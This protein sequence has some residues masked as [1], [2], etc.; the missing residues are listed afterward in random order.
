[1]NAKKI[2]ALEKEYVLQTYAR[3][4]FVIT[5]G[6]GVW[7]IDSEGNRYLDA[8]SGIAVNALGHKHPAVMEAIGQAIAGPI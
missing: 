1:M 7:L 4:A 6:E 2:I 3:P 5:G 8:G